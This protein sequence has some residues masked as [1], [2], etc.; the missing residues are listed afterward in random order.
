ML[1]ERQLKMKRDS[2]QLGDRFPGKYLIGTGGWSHFRIPGLHPL[3]AYSKVFNFVEVNSTFYKIPPQGQIEKWRRTVS[4]DFHFAVRAHRSITHKNRFQPTRE[5]LETLEKLERV[6]QILK[7]EVIHVQTPPSLE[8][9]HV[10]TNN[11]QDLISSSNL[12][13]LRVALEMRGVEPSR[14]PPRFVQTMREYNIIHC[15]DLSKEETPLYESDVLYSR[16]FGRG[17]H[18]VYQPTDEEL[19]KVD[20]KVL[21][22]RA[23]KA[24]LSFHFVRMYKDAARLKIYKQTG[25]FPAITKSTGISS[26]EEVLKEDAEFPST[27]QELMKDQGWKLFDL[28]ASRRI[29][30]N[31]L[32]ERLPHKVYS[33]IREVLDTSKPLLPVTDTKG[34]LNNE[35]A[36]PCSRHGPE[37]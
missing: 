32:L 5:T 27:K 31:D 26:L 36:S 4:P 7:A 18:N 12:G 16:L 34:Q 14:L 19:R 15:V 37:D 13:R 2:T 30:V 3:T 9:D 1:G 11:L 20:Q 6:C 24:M 10:L 21:K 25:R 23:E 22:N 33:S 35:E 17:H 8:I 29:R 28:T